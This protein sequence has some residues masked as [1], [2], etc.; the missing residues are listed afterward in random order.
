MSPIDRRTFLKAAGAL[1]LAGLATPLLPAAAATLRRRNPIQHIIIDLQENRSF[2]HYYGFASFAGKYG[3]PAGYSQPDGSGGSVAP[4]HFTSLTTPDIGRNWFAT[5]G[6]YDGGAMDG[7]YTTDGIN[8][9]GYY[10]AADL[11]FYYSLHDT[12]TLCAN[13]FCSL[14]GPTWPNRFYTAAGTSGGITT[15]GVWGYGTFDYPIVLDLLEDAHL[16]WQV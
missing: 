13:Y 12:S 14:L 4:Y 16:S 7:F 8:A 10:T 9:M 5:H 3:V 15:N 2:D 1:G 11:P 6:E